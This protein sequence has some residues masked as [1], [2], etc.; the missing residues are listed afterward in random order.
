MARHRH[1]WARVQEGCTENPGCWSLGG[2][3]I[4]FAYECP[5]GL[6]RKP[7]HT[8]TRC[9]RIGLTTRNTF[10][11]LMVRRKLLAKGFYILLKGE[12]ND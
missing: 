7:R 3:K 1:T 2:Q 8:H 9:V 10:G 4:L 11:L 5:C 12:S 6:R